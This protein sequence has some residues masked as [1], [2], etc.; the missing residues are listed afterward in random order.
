MSQDRIVVWTPNEL[1]MITLWYGSDYLGKESAVA[2]NRIL[3]TLNGSAKLNIGTESCTKNRC[4][5]HYLRTVSIFQTCKFSSPC[6]IIFCRWDL[7]N[8]PEATRC[9]A[10]L[11]PFWRQGVCWNAIST[12]GIGDLEII[13]QR[14]KK[15]TE[16]LRKFNE[17][18]C[19]AIVCKN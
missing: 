15:T 10:C 1:R 5:P 6:G 2:C 9:R 19:P 7:S 11:W 14:S 12:K 13:R 18:S 3:I 17:I 4:L 8:P 16:M